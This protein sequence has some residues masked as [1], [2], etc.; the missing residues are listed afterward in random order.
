MNKYLIFRTDRIGDFLL[1]AII[2]RSIKINDP[3]SHLT[4]VASEKNYN[5]I[6]SF[7]SVHDVIL[8]N[9]NFK[10]KIKLILQLRKNTYQNI[11]L[12]DNKKRSRFISFFLKAKNIISIKKFS[13]KSHIEI[14][15]KIIYDLNYEFNNSFL[16]TLEEK[17][18][19]SFNHTNFIQLHF[20]EKWENNN[21]IK[22]FV[23]I[24]PTENQLSDFLDLLI[25]QTSKKIIITTGL[26]APKVLKNVINKKN[27][28][29]ILFFKDLDFLELENIVIK[30]DILITC[31]GS[32]SH[33]AAA[34][35]IK[36]LDIIDESYNYSRW[37]EHFRNYNFIYRTN[38][39][40]LANKIMEKLRNF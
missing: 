22:H 35:Q 28:K 8:L 38:F 5:Y 23:D 29:N 40:N 33:L 32:I 6:K 12:H 16:N 30:S 17:E 26:V 19:S 21:Y 1:S 3:E 37:T 11:I 9:N 2:I 25:S 15:K 39:S 7:N 31:H 20:D 27:S 13:D 36:Q 18:E 34:K 10:D 14:I 24:E 4:V